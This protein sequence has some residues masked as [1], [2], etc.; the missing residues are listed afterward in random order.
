MLDQRQALDVDALQWSC[1]AMVMF[2]NG[3]DLQW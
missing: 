1:F 3:H 2:C